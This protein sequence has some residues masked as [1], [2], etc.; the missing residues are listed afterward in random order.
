[1]TSY[2]NWHIPLTSNDIPL[3]AALVSLS[4]VRSELPG[5]GAI[6]QPDISLISK[7]AKTSQSELE[8][9][10]HI[11]RQQ[12]D[13]IHILLGRGLHTMDDIFVTGFTLGSIKKMVK[14]EQSVYAFVAKYLVPDICDFN[15]QEMQVFKDAIRLSF[16]SNCSPLDQFDFNDWLDQPVA[17][18]RDAVGIEEELLCAYYAIEKLRNPYNPASQ[19]LLPQEQQVVAF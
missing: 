8:L 2:I 12:Q 18:I 14:T 13:A 5:T 7:L 3:Q 6:E 16:I 15:E 4:S 19:R 10:K 9:F 1:M 11:D 17:T